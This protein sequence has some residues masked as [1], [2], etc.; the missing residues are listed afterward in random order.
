[1][2]LRGKAAELLVQT[3]PELYQKYIQI[4]KGKKVLYVEAWKAIYGTLKAALLFYKKLSADLVKKGFTINPYDPCVANK[5]V[6]NNKLTVVW[7][8]DDLK[9]SH[10]EPGVIDEL[11]KWVRSNYE[12]SDIGKVKVSRGRTHS[13]LGMTLNFETTGEVKIDMKDYVKSMIED[14]PE[15]TTVIA[16]TP[17]AQHLFQVHDNVKLLD[18]ERAVIMHNMVARGLFL[19]KQARPD[20]QTVIAFLTTRVSQPDIDD[21]KK[22]QHLINYLRG[23]KE[24]CLILN[25][26]GTNIIKWYVDAAYAVHKDMK[27]HTGGIMT[28]GKGAVIATS[29]KQKINTKSSTEAELVGVDDVV[30][31]ILWTNYFLEAQGYASSDT[32]IYQDNKSAILLEK[33]GNLSSSKRTKHINIRYF[34]ITDRVANNEVKIEYCPTDEM[35]ADF[36]TKPLQGSKFIEFRNKILNMEV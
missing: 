8:V 22:L 9:I 13:Y 26:D 24:L 31:R 25:S 29:T 3:A 28:L 35:V 36:F 12:D 1:M 27:S 5:V 16:T 30:G 20:I 34:F 15:K 14:F 23:T 33:N 19:C 17:G 2:R 11:V 6:N 21:W 10:V 7:H 32:I 18:E 4:E